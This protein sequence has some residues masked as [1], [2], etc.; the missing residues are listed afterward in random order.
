MCMRR[1]T[2]SCLS[3]ASVIMGSSVCTNTSVLM[4]LLCLCASDCYQNSALQ[5]LSNSASL[6]RY[7]LSDRWRDDI[8]RDNPLGMHGEV[9]D[10]Y[11]ELI[12]GYGSHCCETAPWP[13]YVRYCIVSADRHDWWMCPRMLVGCLS[14]WSG[15]EE[16]VSP[17]DFK[18]CIG[19]FNSQ[20]NGYRQHDSQELLAFLLVRGVASLFYCCHRFAGV[21]LC[22]PD[23]VW[24]RIQPVCCLF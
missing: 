13:R 23:Q 21:S 3:V 9:A 6:T 4:L 24:S 12:T 10:A 11:R 7:F 5:C 8:N 16:S 15:Y 1:P 19:K 20:F 22:I 18:L 17:T 14:M 2:S